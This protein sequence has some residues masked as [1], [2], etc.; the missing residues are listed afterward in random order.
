MVLLATA[1]NL[2]CPN[3][4]AVQGC[5]PGIASVVQVMP[6]L[7]TAAVLLLLATLTKVQ[8]PYAILDQS[9]E[10][11]NEVAVQSTPLTL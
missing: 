10:S 3:A 6:S 5:A 4:I 8:L 9:L 2:S 1:T 7:L 11:G